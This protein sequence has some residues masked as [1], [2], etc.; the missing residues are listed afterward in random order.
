MGKRGDGGTGPAATGS[1]SDSLAAGWTFVTA[2]GPG[3]ACGNAGL[4]VT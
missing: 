3:W 1:G 4:T 2:A